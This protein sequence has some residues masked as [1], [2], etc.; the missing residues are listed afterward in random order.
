[1]K[2]ELRRA[3]DG[4]GF[5]ICVCGER[6]RKQIVIPLSADLSERIDVMLKEEG[7]GNSLLLPS[8]EKS[9]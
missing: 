2:L 7:I 3:T 1:M 4:T 9:H 8:L 5:A 6:S